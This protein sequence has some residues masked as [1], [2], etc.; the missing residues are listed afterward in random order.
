MTHIEKNFSAAD[1]RF[2]PILQSSQSAAP[3]GKCLIVCYAL[4]NRRKQHDR[5]RILNIH[6][7]VRKEKNHMS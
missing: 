2:G 5:R 6:Y 3:L 1:Q 4:P 7:R